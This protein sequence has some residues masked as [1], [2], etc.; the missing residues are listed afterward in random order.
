MFVFYLV[1]DQSKDVRI[2]AERTSSSDIE[3]KKLANS[4]EDHESVKIDEALSSPIQAGTIDDAIDT[5]IVAKQPEEDDVVMLSDDDI[6][7]NDKFNEFS[8]TFEL[9]RTFFI[10]SN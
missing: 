4:N 6:G 5:P 1:N 10:K 2:E 9:F 8:K 7:K 3:T